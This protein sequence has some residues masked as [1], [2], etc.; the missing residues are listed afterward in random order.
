MVDS[1]AGSGGSSEEFSTLICNPSQTCIKSI[2]DGR[3][4]AELH[5]R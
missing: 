4:C 2:G 1:G 3:L 5:D